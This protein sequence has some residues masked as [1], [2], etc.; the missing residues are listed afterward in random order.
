MGRS[1][2]EQTG[3]GRAPWPWLLCVF[4]GALTSLHR[5]S[6]SHSQFCR[7]L[8]CCNSSLDSL[9]SAAFEPPFLFCFFLPFCPTAVL[10]KPFSP[11][12][13]VLGVLL[14]QQPGKAGGEKPLC[15]T[16]SLFPAGPGSK[17]LGIDG[18]REAIPLTLQIAYSKVCAGTA[19]AP[20]VLGTAL[21][22]SGQ[23]GL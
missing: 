17:R 5:L 22:H 18:D 23:E 1:L 20:P 3:A 15:D 21:G 11:F 2:P 10:S 4:P 6:Q 9:L 19:G 12:L 13:Q 7:V 8:L 16:C 14:Y